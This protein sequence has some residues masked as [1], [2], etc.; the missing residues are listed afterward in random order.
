MIKEGAFIWYPKENR[1][2][3]PVQGIAKY[4]DAYFDKY[5]SYESTEIGIALNNFR[6][7]LVNTYVGPDE[8]ILD[9]GVG[10]GSFIKQ[11]RNC[12]GYDINKKSVDWLI[13]RDIFFD[14]YFATSFNGLDPK[15]IKGITFFDSL[16][17]I[18][19]MEIML[20]RINYQWVFISIPIFK[21][22]PHI[23][24]SKHFRPDEHFHYF[25]QW[26]FITFMLK[27]GFKLYE[28]RDDEI[29]IGREDIYTYVFRRV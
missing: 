18:E 2:Y 23:L 25:T 12:L 14:P 26:S 10:C 17:H 4:N 21:D 5:F 15:T 6:T 16:E 13:D 20:E 7:S 11:R 24:S 1:G 19:K 29:K 22:L 3:Y 27:E 28:A 9:I 8:Q